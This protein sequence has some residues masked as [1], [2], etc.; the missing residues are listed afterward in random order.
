MTSNPSHSVVGGTLSVEGM[1]KDF[2]VDCD[3]KHNKLIVV[4]FHN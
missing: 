3:R 2:I 1:I 4:Y